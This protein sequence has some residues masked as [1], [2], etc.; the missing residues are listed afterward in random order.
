MNTAAWAVQVIL[1]VMLFGA[2]LAKATQ[3]REQLQALSA[4]ELV[5]KLVQSDGDE[6][7]DLMLDWFLFTYS[8]E[9]AWETVQQNA[10]AL[11]DPRLQRLIIT[12]VK[13]NYQPEI[14]LEALNVVASLS[15]SRDQRL[16][17]TR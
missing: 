6:D 1:A 5:E 14:F 15:T 10:N 11:K 9:Q 16:V 7:I 12:K 2:G 17:T 13:D 8:P 4:A 3:K